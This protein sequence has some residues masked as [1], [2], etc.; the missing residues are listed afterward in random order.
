MVNYFRFIYVQ[1]NVGVEHRS[2]KIIVDQLLFELKIVIYSYI[3][4]LNSCL[5]L[6][7]I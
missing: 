1:L 7:I 3:I 2:N 6:S 4:H 5:F